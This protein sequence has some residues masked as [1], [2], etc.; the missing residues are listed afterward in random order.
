M[1][2][3]P[4]RPAASGTMAALL[5]RRPVTYRRA[6]SDLEVG[7]PLG[8]RHTA[9]RGRDPAVPWRNP[10]IAPQLEARLFGSSTALASITPTAS[11]DDVPPRVFAAS[12]TGNDVVQVLGLPPAILA[13]VAVPMEHGSPVHRNPPRIGNRHKSTKL[14][15]RWRRHRD[16]LG[17]PYHAV[18][19]DD[20]GAVGKDE[21][22]RP[23]NG[24]DRQRLE[25]RIE[26]KCARHEERV[27]GVRKTLGEGRYLPTT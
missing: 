20:I 11:G 4:E 21:H 19:H 12:R 3:W 9:E 23:L 27:P 2:P 1:E 16:V 22:Q 10:R 13:G 26:H 14:H 6:P 7:L 15:H 18:G 8:I 24:D 5:S 17:V 25:T